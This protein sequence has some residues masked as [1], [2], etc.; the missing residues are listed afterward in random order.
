MFGL[1]IK[2]PV[3]HQL[4]STIQPGVGSALSARRISYCLHWERGAANGCAAMT[5]RSDSTAESLV[6]RACRFAI[7]AHRRIDQRRKYSKQ[8]YEVHLKAVAD[9][10]ATVSDDQEMIAAAWLHDTVEDTPATLEDIEREFGTGVAR[11]VSDLTDV[12]RPGDGNR[13][14]R[15]AIDRVHTAQAAVQAKTVKLADLIDN[16]RDICSHDERFARVFALEMAA[17]LEVLTDGD[18]RL[19]KQ[20][21]KTLEKCAAQLS[22]TLAP[23]VLLSPDDELSAAEREFSRRQARTLHAFMRA[24]TALNVAEPLRSFDGDM[25]AQKIIDSTQYRGMSVVGLREHGKIVGY[26]LNQSVGEGS[27]NDNMRR[28]RS[29][30]VVDEDAPLADVVLVLTRNDYCFVRV[31]GEVVAVIRRADMQKPLIRMWLFGF[32]TETEM[33]IR[34]RTLLRWPGDSWVQQ[35]SPARLTKARNL[36]E[37]RQRRGQECQL[38]DCVQFSELARILLDDRKEMSAFGFESKSAAKRTI[39][40]FESLRNNLAHAQDIVTYDWAQIARMAK[41]MQANADND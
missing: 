21:H 13:A 16:C 20:A 9:L 32:I 2:T 40:E 17:L 1:N 15:K 29:D 10:V 14:A 36:R 4:L 12:S 6:Q 38:L 24:F 18:E 28:F 34:D 35:L 22:L 19:L 33:M 8:S 39:K 25:P 11:L 3:S 23:P 5:L 37:E 26:M 31:L 30:Q 27:G 41:R 7:Q